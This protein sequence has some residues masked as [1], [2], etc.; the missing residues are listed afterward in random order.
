ME[1]IRLSGGQLKSLQ[2]A[3]PF[4]HPADAPTGGPGNEPVIDPPAASAEGVLPSENFDP[5]PYR[6]KFRKKYGKK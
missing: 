4:E 1:P 3:I 6:K 2:S 5:E